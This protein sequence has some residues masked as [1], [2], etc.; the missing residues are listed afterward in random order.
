LSQETF[1]R[2]H[3]IDFTFNKPDESPEEREKKESR[4]LVKPSS[5]KCPHLFAWQR[6]VGIKCSTI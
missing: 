1:V 5:V 6:F 3:R 4:K 2:T